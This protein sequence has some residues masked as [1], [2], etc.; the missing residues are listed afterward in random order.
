MCLRLTSVPWASLP[1]FS[2]STTGEARTEVLKE[3][4]GAWEIHVN[5]PLLRPCYLI[6]CL[7]FKIKLFGAEVL[8]GLWRLPA[9]P[10]PIR[11]PQ[12]SSPS[13]W[14]SIIVSVFDFYRSF[15]N[16]IPYAKV[17]CYI[18]CLHF[19]VC[20]LSCITLSILKHFKLLFDTLIYYLLI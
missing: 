3:P 20:D 15:K 19:P 1:L 9:P 8:C 18:L 6:F 17:L 7:L 10:P 11:R 16:I 5:V 12:V 13:P 14:F 2:P 4:T